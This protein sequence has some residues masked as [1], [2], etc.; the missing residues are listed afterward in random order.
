MARIRNL[1]LT[2]DAYQH[3]MILYEWIA[4]RESADDDG[5]GVLTIWRISLTDEEQGLLDA[6]ISEL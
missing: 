2:L 3:I 4:R 6:K 1:T 5:R